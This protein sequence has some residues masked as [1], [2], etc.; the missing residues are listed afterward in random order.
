V[1]EDVIK[2][3]EQPGFGSIRDGWEEW[4]YRRDLFDCVVT[5]DVGFIA[6]FINQLEDAKIPTL[7]ALFIK[8]PNEVDQ[9]L[10]NIHYTDYALQVLVASRPELAKSH[11]NFFEVIDRIK[12]PKNQ[13]RAVRGGVNGLF[14][15]EKYDAVIPLI[16]ALENRSFNGRNFK[17]VAIRM[18]FDQGAQWGVKYFVEKFHEH[19][20]IMSGE[21]VLGLVTSWKNDKRR[22]DKSKAAFPFLLGQA[23]QGDLEEAK[24][25]AL[26]KEDA[27]FGKAIDEAYDA[28]LK[29]PSKVPRHERPKK[30]AEL[31]KE[32]FKEIGPIEPLSHE[33]EIGGII[34]G[35]L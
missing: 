17:D 25:S 7:A 34:L 12:H 30:R 10:N 24:K 4:Q 2:A 20:L 31:V 21:Y 8:R 35:Y 27:D 5:K 11:E 23:D 28:L 13:E 19:P 1:K 18:T 3:L 32:A 6:A 26:Y 29:A 33:T 9:V 14:A 16:D 22:R 15:A